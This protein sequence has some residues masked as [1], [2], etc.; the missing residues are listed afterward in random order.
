[1]VVRHFSFLGDSLATRLV[2]CDVL[3]AA[4]D[5]KIGIVGVRTVNVV[6]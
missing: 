3:T 1:M 2:R 6:N 4:R 5:S